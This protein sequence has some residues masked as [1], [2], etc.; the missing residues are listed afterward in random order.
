M[1]SH[2]YSNSNN[3]IGT[4]KSTEIPRFFSIH[5]R[6]VEK[7]AEMNLCFCKCYA[8]QNVVVLFG[9]RERSYE[10]LEPKQTLSYRDI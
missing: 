5:Q 7:L 6:N 2:Q 4:A 8:K 1:G 10:R 3:R 9:V